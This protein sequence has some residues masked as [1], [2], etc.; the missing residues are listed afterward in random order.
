MSHLAAPDVLAMTVATASVVAAAVIDLRTRRVPNPL[1][2][3]TALVG[4]GLGLLADRL[5]AAAHFK[6]T[7]DLP[8][9]RRR[10]MN[11]D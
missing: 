3:A 10:Y 4:L 5:D 7:R 6:N 11:L 1:T 9:K 2:G 8:R